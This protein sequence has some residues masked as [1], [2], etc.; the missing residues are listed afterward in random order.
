[1][2]HWRKV[3]Q[4]QGLL[5]GDALDHFIDYASTPPPQ[6]C[7]EVLLLTGRA[8]TGKSSIAWALHTVNPSLV[9]GVWDRN[10]Q[11]QLRP[12]RY[13]LTSNISVVL[14]S[15]VLCYVS[16]G[17]DYYV[18]LRVR[19]VELAT[20]VAAADMVPGFDATLAAEMAGHV[21]GLTV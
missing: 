13:V 9:V 20:K 15:W 8:A 16:G 2:V 21:A 7:V 11:Q 17:Q 5:D 3:M 14:P 1:M 4:M 12:G 18:P 10:L 6:D 19:H